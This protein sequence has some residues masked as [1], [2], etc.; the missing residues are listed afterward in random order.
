M[1]TRIQVESYSRLRTQAWSI[2][3]L[4]YKCGIDAVKGVTNDVNIRGVQ[5]EDGRRDYVLEDTAGG[6]DHV[7]VTQFDLL[8]SYLEA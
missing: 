7:F 2:A 3:E 4:I 8:V 5:V 1:Q 6:D